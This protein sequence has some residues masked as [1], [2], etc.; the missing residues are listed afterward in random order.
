MHGCTWH[1]DPAHSALCSTEG[2]TYLTS[3]STPQVDTRAQPHTEHVLRRPVHQVEVEVVLQLR[4]VQHLEW[5]LRD[6][7][8]SL[9]AQTVGQALVSVYIY[10]YM[11]VNMHRG[12]QQLSAALGLTYKYIMAQK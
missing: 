3:T 7:T 5:D 1:G 9:Q 8:H 12:E 4:G 11:G 10:I 6:L 2:Q